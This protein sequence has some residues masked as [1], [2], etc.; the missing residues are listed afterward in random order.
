METDNSRH[1]LRVNI[2]PGLY[3]SY[4]KESILKYTLF[5]TWAYILLKYAR[6]VFNRIP[7]LSD[8]I[9]A[10][11]AVVV[12]IPI[13]LSLPAWIN[14]FSIGDYLFYFINVFYLVAC[15]AFFP[16][17]TAFLN[18]EI[19]YSVFCVFPFYFFGRLFSFHDF[20]DKLVYLS[21]ICIL[22]ELFYFLVYA[23][24]NKTVSEMANDDNMW[25]AYQIMPHVALVMWSML[26]RFR[27]W[28]ALIFVAGCLFLL[29]CGTRG[30][31]VCMGFFGVIYFFFYMRFKGAIYVKAG[32]ILAIALTILT[33]ESTLY[34]VV[35]TFTRLNLSTRIIEKLLLGD[36]GNDSHR[37]MLRDRL[38]QIL[39]DGDYFW[40][41]GAFG[42]RNFDIIYPH[43]LPLDFVC[44]F[45]YLLGSMLFA[46]L[47]YLI[48]KAMWVTRGTKEQISIVFLFSL[49][50]IKLLMSNT[51]LSEPY[52]YIFI[53]ACCKALLCNQRSKKPAIDA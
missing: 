32:I 6:A 1:I 25:A 20:F 44:T 38:I 16:E 42:C 31:F 34:Y 5:F 40:G 49:S 14:R 17:N 50:I 53:G 39:D 19:F 45:G 26:Q 43:L 28:K 11:I 52:F 3:V 35:T 37:S 46:A 41:F 29:S 7:T 23:Q 47:C 13:L 30:T 8:N 2:C 24:Q 4:N 36:L 22:L 51:F 33:L 27:I 48:I 10:C 9:D 15:Y 18:E 21:T 12:S